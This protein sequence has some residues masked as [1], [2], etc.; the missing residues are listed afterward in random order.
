MKLVSDWVGLENKKNNL[1][2]SKNRQSFVESMFINF[3]HVSL[4]CEQIILL[5]FI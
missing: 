2:D 1:I 3:K 4:L 5:F